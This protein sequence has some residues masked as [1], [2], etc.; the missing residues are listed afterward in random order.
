MPKFTEFVKRYN[1]KSAISPSVMCAD[2]MVLRETL[3]VFSYEKI[4][5]LHVDIMD[6]TF[7]PN[8]TF[9]TDF[10]RALRRES[11]IPL[12]IHLMVTHPEEK[13]GWFDLQPGEMVSVHYESTQNLSLALAEI[14]NRGAKAFVA[15]NP[16]TPPEVL[17]PYL[18]QFDGLLVMTVQP[19][20][21]GQ[22]MTPDAL[23]KIASCREFLQENGHGVLPVEVDGNVSFE[24]APKM[25]TAGANVFVAGSSGVFSQNATVSENIARLRQLI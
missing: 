1:M 8:Y 7:V 14:R 3:Q 6:G 17:T 24:N 15:L 21:A 22:K 10:C 16:A 19:G 5:F 25:R 18:G 11:S 13:I 2:I 23:E 4:E 20:F 12:D 9:G